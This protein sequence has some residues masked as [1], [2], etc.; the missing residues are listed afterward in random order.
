MRL[1]IVL[2]LVTGVAMWY[3]WTDGKYVK[4]LLEKKQE[5]M[6]YLQLA[7]IALGALFLYWLIR[8]NPNDPR[9]ML[10]TTNEYIKYLPID[11]NTKSMLSP[12]LDFT[13]NHLYKKE[14][15]YEGQPVLQM[16]PTEQYGE[17]R[18]MASGKAATTKR[19]VSE[20]KKKFVASRQNWKCGG[21][22]QM[23]KAWYEVD[24]KIRLEHGG[25]NHVDNLVAM[26]RECHGEKTMVENL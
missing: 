24:H 6:K 15:V 19:N 25:S 8:K 22:G 26:C 1:E 14:Q 23:L 3:V 12:I 13:T 10:A 17:R 20:S 16:T 4:L 5:Y 7:G 21:C 11:G 9:K 18:I 2:F